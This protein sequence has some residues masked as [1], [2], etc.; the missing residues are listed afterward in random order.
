MKTKKNLPFLS[1]L[2]F[3]FLLARCVKEN[4]HP[5]QLFLGVYHCLCIEEE[6][7]YGRLTIDTF[8]LEIEIIPLADDKI[9]FEGTPDD[10]IIF[11]GS[12]FVQNPNYPN[13][14]SIPSVT[15]RQIVS[16]GFFPERDSMALSRWYGIHYQDYSKLLCQGRK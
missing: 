13:S 4:P 1:A 7:I 11:G 10:K 2:L 12:E 9:T 15:Y 8:P 3:L 16:I 14:F 5:L 6:V